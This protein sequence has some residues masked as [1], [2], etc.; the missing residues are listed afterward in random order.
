[1][2]SKIS[3][4]KFIA[5]V[6]LVLIAVFCFGYKINA[7]DSDKQ[8][9]FFNQN[10]DLATELE[11]IDQDFEGV[12]DFST[13]DLG[14]DGVDEIVISY[15]YLDYPEVKIFRYDGSLINSFKPYPVGY[16]GRINVSTGDFDN[17]GKDEIITAPGEGGGPHVR[18]FDGYGE[19]KFNKG[20]FVADEKNRQGVEVSI[21]DV[22]GDG[23][24]E[25]IASL[26]EDG[27]NIIRFFS[28]KGESL[29][30]EIA[31]DVE[32]A[33]EPMKVNSSDL[34][35]D[36]KDEIVLGAGMG[37]KPLVKVLDYKGKELASFYAYGENFLGGVDVDGVKFN[38]SRY[39]IT[40]AGFSGGPHVR[41]FDLNGEVKL[42]PTFFV[43]D[44]SFRGGLNVSVGHFNNGHDEVVVIPQTVSN[45]SELTSS[46]KTI[47]VDISDQRLY[48]YDRGKLK[49]T[50]LISSGRYGYDTPIGTY[51]VYRKKALV[52]MSWY[53]GE[54]NPNNYDLDNV[55]HVL[56]FKGPYT[57]HGAFWHTNWG[58]RMSHGCVN[59]SLPHAEW[60]YD[61]SPVG[62]KVIIQE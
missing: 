30:S 28:Y 40:A 60:L 14:G 18:I 17:D 49:N 35:G 44:K 54:N 2:K 27:K 13:V 62:T 7:E 33:F 57:L 29:F 46:G 45:A 25:I 23:Q 56:Y 41:F 10:L 55:P 39:I 8:V 24:A 50:F 26:L 21:G 20:F 48:T 53:Y 38:G 59:I 19:L 4:K 42:D 32:D 31:L 12:M 43:Y 16:E 6:F 58:H 51:L 52:R 1:M 47:K 37:N 5:A 15:G 3:N 36:G 11:L 61:W 22:N 34:N 9:R